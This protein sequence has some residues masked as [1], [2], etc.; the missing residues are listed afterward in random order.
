MKIVRA[1]KREELKRSLH[2][3]IKDGWHVLEPD[4]EFIDNWHIEAICEHLEAV[5]DGRIRRLLINIAPGSLKS[6]S[7]SCYW[8]AWVW[9]QNPGWRSIFASY[10]MPLSTR[11]SVKC[12]DLIQS[13]WYQQ[14]FKPQWELKGDQNVKTWFANTARGVRQALAVGSGGLGWK[15]DC[16]TVD[17]PADIEAQL[18]ETALEDV[19]FWWHTKMSTRLA[20]PRNGPRVCIMQ[21]LHER[22]L[23]GRIL[24]RGNVEHLCLP[25]EYDP[26]ERCVTSIWDKDPRTEPGELLFPELFTEQVIEEA[27]ED[28][29]EYGFAGQHNQKPAPPG[30]GELKQ[31]WWRFW[32]PRDLE[33]PPAPYRTVET[34]GSVFEHPQMEIPESFDLQLQSWDMTFK[35]KRKQASER[36]QKRSYVVGQLWATQEHKRFLLDQFRDRWS[37]TEA[38]DQV[39]T[40]SAL[41][42]LA[43]R[44]LVED[45]AN[46]AAICD[47]LE[48]EIG[49]FDLIPV[50]GDK[51]ARA[52]AASHSIKGGFVYLPHPAIF[53]W[54]KGFLFE[55]T[56]FPKGA[57]NDQVDACSQALIELRGSGFVFV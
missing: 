45:A 51:E 31:V 21:R 28:L 53:A 27:R 23:S 44:K 11:D 14:T 9:V 48:D 37:F 56:M 15:A 19:D 57:N 6:L 20:D 35:G 36:A 24:A 46:G 8:P 41:W 22:D 10:A 4:T 2:K 30:G 29:G 12:R 1:I 38:V 7:V 13:D 16:V 34:D 55:T 25:T 3:F 49:G 50:K 47:T 17:D 5:T 42:P 26:E 18:S 52:R 33:H 54:V 40:F 39:R 43:E 32:Y